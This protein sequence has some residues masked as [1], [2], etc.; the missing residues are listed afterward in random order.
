MAKYQT[1]GG[2]W[3]LAFCS[4]LLFFG[5]LTVVMTFIHVRLS[6]GATAI[7][8]ADCGLVFGATVHGREAAGPGIARRVETAARLYGEEKLRRLIFT[9]GRGDSF[10]E[11]EA[12]VMATLAG[13][14]GVPSSVIRIEEQATSTWENLQFSKT[15]VNDCA[16]I[17][18]I[19]DRY[20]LRRIVL[21]ASMQNFAPLQTYPADRSAGPLFEQASLLRETLGNL[22]YT[23]LPQQYTASLTEWVLGLLN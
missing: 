16:S 13:N 8:P 4:T 11:S 7:F 6:F 10:K 5:L 12:V 21:L 9:G 22:Y 2:T 23:F 20:H 14:L 19:S 3:I 17:V 1:N 15:L 18:A